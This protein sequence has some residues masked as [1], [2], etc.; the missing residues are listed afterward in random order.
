[1]TMACWSS[2]AVDPKADDVGEVGV[3]AST[4]L[5]LV[6][7]GRD[8]GEVHPSTGATPR[9]ATSSGLKEKARPLR[10]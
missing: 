1:M 5:A 9:K 4:S 10:V 8:R 7:A 6:S 2:M 3:G